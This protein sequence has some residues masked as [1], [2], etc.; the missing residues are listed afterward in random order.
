M[1]HI[2]ADEALLGRLSGFAE[3]IEIRTPEG[4]VLGRYIPEISPE[5]H[6]FYRRTE[7]LFDWEEAKRTMQ[8]EQ[9]GRSLAEIMQRW[10]ALEQNG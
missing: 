7:K 8:T 4:R 5:A 1:T 6:A 9:G 3:A 10:Q 2:V